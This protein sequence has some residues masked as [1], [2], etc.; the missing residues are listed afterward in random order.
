MKKNSILV[1]TAS[2]LLAFTCLL[3]CCEKKSTTSDEINTPKKQPDPGAD[4]IE[5]I[6]VDVNTRKGDTVIYAALS[7]VADDEADEIHPLDKEYNAELAKSRTNEKNIIRRFEPKWDAE[8]NRLYKEMLAGL[9]PQAA[10][11]LKTSQREWIKYR[12]AQ[13][14]M[15]G[16]LFNE[17]VAPSMY[18]GF[19]MYARM[20]VTRQRVLDLTHRWKIYKML[21]RELNEVTD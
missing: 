5:N 7:V 13:F 4:A 17:G 8:L 18:I 16:A 10:A 2:V 1:F 6:R 3:S 21:R 14:K 11:A 20:N 15:I 19:S 9:N 12:D